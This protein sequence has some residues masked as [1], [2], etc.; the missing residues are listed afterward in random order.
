MS[1]FSLY[2]LDRLNLGQMFHIIYSENRKIIL[3]KLIK[4]TKTQ[5]KLI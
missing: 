5:M 3:K 1:A 4:P 2:E